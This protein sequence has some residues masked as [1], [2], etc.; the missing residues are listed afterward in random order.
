MRSVPWPEVL[1]AL[2][3]YL[4]LAVVLT[5]PLI[6]N[7]STSIAGGGH[8]WDPAGYTWDLWRID[9]FGLHVWGVETQQSVGAPFGR[10]AAS[11]SNITLLTFLVPA[12]ILSGLFSPIVAMN[13]TVLSGLALSGAA[14]HLLVRWLGAG[15]G[16]AVWAGAAL[17][18]SPW[19]TARAG[20]HVPLTHV[21][22]F[23]LAILV[24]IRWIRRPDLRRSLWLGAVLL[25]TW[26]TNPYY[27]TI[28]LFLVGTIVAVGVVLSLRRDGVRTAARSLMRAAVAVI[29][30]V[31]AP[32]AL[33]SA[34][35]SG[36]LDE[37]TRRDPSELLTYGAQLREYLVPAADDTFFAG[38]FGPER[39]ADLGTTSIGD[40]HR[41]FVGFLTLALVAAAVGFAIGRPGMFGARQRLAL[42]CAGP[43]VLVLGLLSMAS[44]QTVFGHEITMPSRLVFEYIPYLR[45]FSRF[46]IAVLVVLLMVAAIGLHAL[47][48]NRGPLWS[49][50]VISCALIIS[51]AELPPGA[52]AGTAIASDVPV[53]INGEPPE[54]V[55]AWAWLRDHPQETIVLET[56]GMPDEWTERFFMY[57]QIVHGHRI[58]NGNVPAQQIAHSMLAENGDPRWSGVAARL[59][60]LGIGV[61]TVHPFAYD[62][63]G[64]TA[65][66]PDRPPAGFEVLA[67]FPDGSAV[68]R[69]T[70]APAPGVALPFGSG[71]WA[72]ERGAGGASR[73]M[74]QEG[75]VAVRVD[76]A[77][78]YRIDATAN[79]L[80]GA[81]AEIRLEGPGV[82]D[83]AW[84]TVSVPTPVT[85]TA[86]LPAGT[87]G[88]RL[89]SRRPAEVI[90]G[91]DARAVT[92]NVGDW[93]VA[94]ASD[95]G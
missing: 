2:A 38:L 8:G 10:E 18:L 75:D 85:F 76:R 19:L 90:G 73:W 56:A 13:V 24:G 33:L 55:P 45:A 48:R 7:F 93:T 30:L 28:N 11:S 72:P 14:M 52:P 16:P 46:G 91:G 9:N 61:V 78:T 60:A 51:F 86:E 80:R 67:S 59:A 26:L 68:W 57:G 4:V 49:V 54:R 77:G 58:A 81:P 23:P 94:R 25:L 36:A 37:G 3:G 69:V 53:R 71:W 92:V 89:V 31:L 15:R 41:L 70:A 17:M 88:L 20:V 79:G 43:L 63:A 5:W 50:A 42:L 22:C 74:M 47:T 87:T 39:W 27:G 29:G 6:T 40:E 32:L 66:D 1:L 35:S 44:P 12:W 84:V 65:P 82:R 64:L 62:R 95:G 34:T 21:W 83:T